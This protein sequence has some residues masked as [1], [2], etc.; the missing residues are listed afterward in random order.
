MEQHFDGIGSSWT[1]LYKPIKILE[2]YISE[3]EK[4]EEELTLKYMK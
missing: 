1:K 4:E 2:K 3:N